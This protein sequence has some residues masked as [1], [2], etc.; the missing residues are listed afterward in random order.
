[1]LYLLV[2][3]GD[4]CY[5]NAPECCV[6]THT[7]YRV[8]INLY[9]NWTYRVSIDIMLVMKLK[10]EELSKE[11]REITQNRIDQSSKW[12][13]ALS[14]PMHIGLLGIP[15]V[16]HNLLSKSWEPCSCN[17]VSN[18]PYTQTSNILRHPP[19]KKRD[20]PKLVF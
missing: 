19:P 2:F 7:A 6:Y 16:P 1:M 20:E 15:S 3:H 14:L 8:H 9:K 11:G 13:R 10:Q 5:M 12:V 18:C 17:K 4:N